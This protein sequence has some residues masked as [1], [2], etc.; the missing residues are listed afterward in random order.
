MANVNAVK[1]ISLPTGEDLRGGFAE[2]LIINS[3]GQVVKARS[4]A[5]V[6][7]GA[8]A[9]EPSAGA[10]GT[11]VPVALVGG[12]GKL[13]M[14]AGAAIA[15]G[16]LI[17]ASATSGRVA[18][19]ANAAALAANRMA[20]GIALESAANGDIFE[21]LA[22]TVNAAADVNRAKQVF[23]PAGEDLTGDVAEALTVN[24]SGQVVKISAATDVIVGAL[25]E[26][27]SAATVGTNVKVTL[28]GG[29]GKLEMKAGAAI[30]TGNLIVASATSGRV[31]G[32]A[33]IAALA[34]NQ[35]AVGI[36]L[37]A[38]TAGDVFEVLAMTI[39]GPTA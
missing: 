7:A 21:V 2:A 22:M 4:A 15:A 13:K 10:V 36:A 32:V 23:L 33:D 12:G 39:A 28:V 37:E 34:A 1:A 25:A 26:E 3:L 30:T 8:L 35:M 9:E 31:A 17:V 19:V 38:A 14:K 5:S 6:I 16:D 18:G 11:S 24:A 29:G 20:V 27:P